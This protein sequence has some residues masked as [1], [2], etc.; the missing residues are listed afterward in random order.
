MIILLF[1][2]PGC[3][4]G[5]QS[6]LLAQ[7]FGI[8][9]ISTG[10]MFR[11]ECKAGTRLGKLACSILQAGGL[12][13]DEI[14]NQ[15][16]AGRIAQPDCRAGFLLDG[17]PRTL[18]QAIHLDKLLVERGLPRPIAIHLEV[19][20]QVLAPRIMARRQCGSCGR[21]YNLLSQ[22]PRT[23]EICD[24]DHAVLLRR[25]DDTEAV[26]AARLKAY[27][28]ATGPV[29]AHYLKQGGLRVDGAGTPEQVFRA[30]ER[31]LASCGYNGEAR[32]AALVK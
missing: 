15:I 28:E 2:A 27:T 4:K 26:V 7:R 16:V 1:G 23:P 3:G 17:Y 22:P 18:P 6:A 19:P 5:T 14:A 24:V 32:L 31:R 10:D 25:E 9:A 30:I 13:G 20:V 29:I 11:A 21:I 8:P 12:V